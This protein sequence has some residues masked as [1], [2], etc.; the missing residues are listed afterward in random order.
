MTNTPDRDTVR[1]AP[2]VRAASPG[3]DAALAAGDARFEKSA[4]GREAGSRVEGVDTAQVTAIAGQPE[5]NGEELTPLSQRVTAPT[6]V[7]IPAVGDGLEWRP[8]RREDLPALLELQR[9]AN[10]V[11]NPRFVPRLD[12]LEEDFD[13]AGFDP[14]RDTVIA[15]DAEGRAVAYGEAYQDE[16][17]ETVVTVHLNGQVHPERRREG[18]GSAVLAWQEARGLQQLAASELRLPGWLSAGAEEEAAAPRALLEGAGYARV[19]WWMTM[20]RDLAEPIPEVSLGPE[21]RWEV[22]GPEWSEPS[23]LLINAAFRDHWGSQPTSRADWQASERLAAF[24]PELGTVIVAT[25]PD[26]SE[27][28]VGA[29]TVEVNEEEWGPNG[30]T[31]GYV[32][33]LGVA[34]AW[35][36]R[37]IAQ[38][39]LAR[40]FAALRA[41]GLERAVLDVD[42]ESPTGA[43]GLYAR[44]GF[45]ELARSVSLVKVF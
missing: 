35:R 20:D 34:R 37:G 4:P 8:L 38:A 17:A 28:V 11:D 3:G 12:A 19:R 29:L 44:A 2:R 45:R 7:V 6:E 30:F 9:A 1:D 22:Y 15:F 40:T 13:S 41:E 25:L 42:S 16:E 36:G 39:L 43:D 5:R 31:F 23:R 21:L 10:A 24:R 14:D 33:V 27:E 18:I 32:E 26:G